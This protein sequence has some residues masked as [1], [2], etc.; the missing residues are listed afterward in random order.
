MTQRKKPPQ[1]KAEAIV[2]VRLSC[3]YSGADR[4]WNAGDLVPVTAVEADRLGA[5]GVVTSTEGRA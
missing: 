4:S 5:L 1:A 2:H 3:V